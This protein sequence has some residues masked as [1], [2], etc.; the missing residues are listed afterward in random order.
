MKF[1]PLCECITSMCFLLIGAVFF[2]AACRS[3][4]DLV[5]GLL[6][7]AQRGFG[8]RGQSI[9]V[10]D[11]AIAHR[12]LVEHSAAFLDRP[13]SAVPSTI[14]SRNRHYNILS[15]PYGPYWRATRR[16]VAAGV[17]HPSRLRQDALADTRTRMLQDLVSSIG[18]GAP[19]GESLHFAVYSIPSSPRCVLAW[20]PSPSSEKHASAPCRSSSATSS[21]R[22]P[23]SGC[24]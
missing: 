14:L 16:N 17:L 18:S 15:A 13:T 4:T 10:T 22:C 1:P 3:R 8:G 9:Q 5:S 12:A 21:W 19:A 2:L 24:S 6:R 11:R 20:T 23:P 7:K